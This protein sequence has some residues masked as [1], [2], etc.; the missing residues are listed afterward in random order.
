[1]ATSV[2]VV[3]SLGPKQYHFKWGAENFMHFF[4]LTFDDDYL[5]GGIPLDLKSIAD[6]DHIFHLGSISPGWANSSTAATVK[7]VGPVWDAATQ[8]VKL[9][10]FNDATNDEV[11]TAVDITDVTLQCYAIGR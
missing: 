10:H 4:T 11:T 7:M 2:S 9:V 5:T 8:K 3:V 6:I 1:M